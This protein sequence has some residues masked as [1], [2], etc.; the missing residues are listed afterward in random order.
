M[1]DKTKKV[2]I[3][4]SNYIPW[5]G[6]FDLIG[7]VDEFILYDDMQYT[8]RDWRNRNLIKTPRGTEWL[9][10][11]VEA[12][13]KFNQKIRD[14]KISDRGWGRKHFAAISH[15]YA[16]SEF[17]KVYREFLEQLYLDGSETY[18]SDVNYRF[19][20]TICEQLGITTK[21]SWSS[22]YH[23]IEGKSERLLN[24]CIE[25]QAGIYFS[26]PAAKAY[27]DE[28]LFQ[29][30]GI[31]IHW[32]DYSG[33]PEYVQLHPPFVHGV[34]IID[35]LLNKGPS[36]RHYLKHSLASSNAGST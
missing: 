36:A 2:A 22:D 11:P 17:Y 4:Q 20:R 24:L 6:Y 30:N 8:R 5:K 12:K 21:I 33:Y 7:S 31:R 27:M 3:V 14:T 9:T 13:G 34:S 16:K 23:L 15:N 10:I 26:G 25:A 18:L 29:R 1:N 19:I 32:M 28:G 35:L